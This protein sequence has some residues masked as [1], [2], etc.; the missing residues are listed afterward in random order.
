MYIFNCNLQDP[1][2]DLVYGSDELRLDSR[3]ARLTALVLLVF[4]HLLKHTKLSGL[5]EF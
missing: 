5:L 2:V 1:D 4:F 3:F